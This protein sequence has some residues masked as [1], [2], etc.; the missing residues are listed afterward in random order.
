V[1]DFERPTMTE[2]QALLV[3][4]RDHD[5]VDYFANAT[6]NLNPGMTR[7]MAETLVKNRAQTVVLQS[8]MITTNT[9]AGLEG[10]IRSATTLPGRK[11]IFFLS[12]GFFLDDRTSD[13]RSR[14][15]RITSA[16]ARSG[17]VIYSLDARGLVATLGD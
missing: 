14:L 8:G 7:D 11:L 5:L 12:G 13:S 2:Y 16:A 1:R 17:V 15:Q 3:T 10:L 9:L 6:M 4:N